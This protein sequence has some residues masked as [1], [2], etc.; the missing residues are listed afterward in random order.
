M[1]LVAFLLRT[2]WASVALAILAGAISGLSS[3]GLIALINTALNAETPSGTTLAWSF[4]GLCA[5]ALCTRIASEVLLTHLGQGTIFALHMH[6]SRQIL[7]TSLRH[8]EALGAHRLLAALTEDVEAIT[9]AFTWYPVVFIN[10]AMVV[11]CLVYM[12]WLSW[13]LL[14]VLLAFMVLGIVS[15]RLPQHRAVASLWLAREANDMLYRHFRAQTDGIKEL[16]LHRERREAFLTQV[17]QATA[18]TFRRHSVVGMA[19]YAVARSWGNLLFYVFIGLL[20]FVL[21]ALY[22]VTAQTVSGYTLAILYMMTPVASLLNALPDLGRA[23]VALQKIESLGLSLATHATEGHALTPLSSPGASWERLELVRVTY[24]Y[25]REKEDHSFMLGPI[26]LTFRPGELVFLIGGNGSG[27]TTLAKLLVG[28][29]VPE[30]GEIR[31]RGEPITDVNREAYRQHFSAVFSDFYLFD[32]L[33]GLGSEQFDTQAQAYLAQLQLNHKVQVEQGRL[34]TLDLSLGQRKR[35]AL[36]TAYLEDRCF[37]VFDEWAAD[38]DPLFK[39]IFY[40][41]LLPELKARGKTVLVITHDNQYV[42][43]ADRCIEMAEGQCLQGD[44]R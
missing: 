28:L 13:S 16:K 27:K 22:D 7:A 19:I 15:Y 35:L 36:L 37:Y 44:A 34:S 25:Y 11:G 33:L 41:Q 21:P 39:Q 30:A 1:H 6:L 9:D 24:T 38:Q 2:S 12:G 23:S 8:L 4:M 10:G 17:L 18:A 29:Y 5:I 26:D 32:S 14:L 31:L 40:L 20:L 43:I 3:A 42:H